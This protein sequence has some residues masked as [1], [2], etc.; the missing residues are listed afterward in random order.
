MSG[1]T[2]TYVT[3]KSGSGGLNLRSQPLIDPATRIGGLSEGSAI[4][5][6][7][8][9]GRTGTPAGCMC[10]PSSPRRPATAS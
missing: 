5:S 10:P 4:W 3:P 8:R 6:W 7:N 1:T 9:P 2:P